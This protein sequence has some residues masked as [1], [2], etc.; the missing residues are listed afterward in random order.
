MATGIAHNQKEYRASI[1]LNCYT[2]RFRPKGVKSGLLTYS[3]V[4]KNV[5]FKELMQ[6]F[7]KTIDLGHYMTADTERIISLEKN[8]KLTNHIYSGVIKKGHSGHETYIEE[9]KHKNNKPVTVGT[10][11]AHQYNSS[12]FYFLL[13]LPDPEKEYIVFMAQSYKQFGFKEVFEEAFK[14]FF[15]E[16]YDLDNNLMCEFGTLSIASL[17]KKYVSEGRIRKLRL[18]K[19]G[20]TSELEDVVKDSKADI[21]DYDVE[22][23]IIA[24]RSKKNFLDYLKG[25]D[26]ENTSFVELFKIN[27]FE[28]DEAIVDVSAAGRKRVLNFSDPDSFVA[29]YD[30]TNKIEINKTTKH[31]NFDKLDAEANDILLNEVIPNLKQ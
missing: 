24:K 14:K 6:Q 3:E 9:V 26:L 17:F 28:Y 16:N 7:I 15:Y 4:F 25:L 19:H 5:S 2:I 23:S 30:V 22:L 10:V 13:S 31:P 21:N 11:H 1:N 8:L 20:L 12:P 29:S 18:R 27:S